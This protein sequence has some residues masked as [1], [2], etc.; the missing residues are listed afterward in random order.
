MKK[1][2]RA[3]S[4]SAD[5]RFSRG[6]ESA[7]PLSRSV[8]HSRDGGERPTGTSSRVL[9]RSRADLA[10]TRSRAP[11]GGTFRNLSQSLETAFPR[12]LTELPYDER[13]SSE[14]H[15]G[16]EKAE[17]IRDFGPSSEIARPAR[18]AFRTRFNNN[19]TSSHS[20]SFLHLGKQLDK[21]VASLSFERRILPRVTPRAFRSL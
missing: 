1:N 18:G 19:E 2:E 8:P 7:R 14:R 10:S 20:N 15:L 12:H 16:C 9:S 5:P 11:L 3:D 21:R 6:V 13:V 4:R 17:P